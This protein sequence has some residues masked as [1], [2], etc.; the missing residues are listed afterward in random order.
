MGALRHQRLTEADLD[1]CVLNSCTI[2]ATEWTQYGYVGRNGLD[3]IID[4]GRQVIDR[5]TFR[6]LAL[7]HHLLPV[8][9]VEAL[10]S[11]GVTLALDASDILA[12]AQRSGVNVALHGHQHKP[13]I[14]LYQNLALNGDV[15]GAPL[16]VVANGSAG[17]KNDRLPPGE[18]NTY[19]LF[20]LRNDAIDLWIRELR[21]D[22]VAGAQI[23]Q[24][25]LPTVP[26]VP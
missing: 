25:S 21:L 17:A 19:C 14:A 15:T 2:A 6:F 24:G 4:L 12:A 11:K 1:V 10:Q 13:K 16:H 7:H 22:A 8:A 26:A 23:F 20:R 9:K 3:A 18:R 5:P